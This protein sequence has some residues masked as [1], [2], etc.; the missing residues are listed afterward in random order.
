MNDLWVWVG[1]TASVVILLL[2]DLVLVHRRPHAVSVREAAIWT[3]IWIALALLFCLGILH[4]E[5]SQAALE[6]LT[7][8]VIEK[9]LSLDNIFVFVVIFSYFN[10]P[11]RLKHRVLFWGILGAL[12]MRGT[13]IAAGA[14]LISHFDWVLYVFGAFLVITGVRLAIKEEHGVEPGRN[15]V[16]RFV[17]GFLPVIDSYADGKFFV[18]RKGN[19]RESWFGRA[20]T[21]L[22]IVLVTVETTDVIFALDSIPAIFGVTRDPF[23]VYSSNVFAILG[24]RSLYFVLA[25]VIDRFNYLRLG[26]AAVLVFVGVKMLIEDIYEMPIFLSLAVVVGLIGIALVA[27]LL[28]PKPREPALTDEASSSTVGG[29]GRRSG[30]VK[31][32]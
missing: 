31:H 28:S 18:R 29:R 26:L 5:G 20:A 17:R 25:G 32:H 23:I 7:G 12:V 3:G 21:P 19:A 6:Y 4:F 9:S 13:M 16:I 27:S 8:Y 24:L 2:V 22:F 1:F 15:P 14:Y 11:D 10:V 30:A